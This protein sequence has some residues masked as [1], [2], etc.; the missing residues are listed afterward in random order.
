MIYNH[1]LALAA[2]QAK[3]FNDWKNTLK[4]LVMHER[5]LNVI[6]KKPNDARQLPNGIYITRGEIEDSI[7]DEDNYYTADFINVLLLANQDKSI[8]VHSAI[9]DEGMVECF[10]KIAFQQE[11]YAFV[12]INIAYAGNETN[13]KNHWVALI[14]DRETSL[15][16]YLDPAHKPYTDHLKKFICE[17]IGNISIIINPIDFQISEKEEGFIR[18]CGVYVIEIFNVFSQKASVICDLSTLQVVLS[19]IPCG[20]AQRIRE[21]RLAHIEKACQILE[22]AGELLSSNTDEHVSSEKKGKKNEN[23]ARQDGRHSSIVLQSVL[24]QHTE[25]SKLL[26][27]K[28]GKDDKERPPELVDTNAMHPYQ[29]FIRWLAREDALKKG[30]YLCLSLDPFDHG[31]NPTFSVKVKNYLHF[32]FRTA[33]LPQKDSSTLSRI[34]VSEIFSESVGFWTEKIWPIIFSGLLLHDG[35]TYFSEPLDRYGNTVLGMLVGISPNQLAWG[36]HLGGDRPDDAYFWIPIGLPLLLSS[37]FAIYK[38]IQRLS[39][40]FDSKPS[41][42][43]EDTSINSSSRI[44]TLRFPDGDTSVHLE[45]EEFKLEIDNPGLRPEASLF[46]LLW[47]K[48]LS[49]KSRME[50]LKNIRGIRGG[51]NLFYQMQSLARLVDGFDLK[52][53]KLA[54]VTQQESLTFNEIYKKALDSIQYQVGMKSSTFKLKHSLSRIYCE[55]LLWSLGKSQNSLMHLVFVPLAFFA[56]YAKLR[57]WIF[58]AQKA[59]VFHNYL[60]GLKNCGYQ[61][62]TWLY[63][64]VSGQFECTVCGDNPFVYYSDVFTS[65]G[66]LNGLFSQKRTPEE[67][68]KYLG[69]ILRSP[70]FMWIDLSQQNWL[71]WELQQ[72]SMFLNNISSVTSHLKAFNLSYPTF[73]PIFPNASHLP[74]FKE[75][76]KIVS[77]D[78]LDIHNRGMGDRLLAELM[79]ALQN[80]SLTYLDLSFNQLT[81]NAAIKIGKFIASTQTLKTL[82]IARNPLGDAGIRH[83]V[84]ALTNSS[85]IELDICDTY[86]GAEGTASIATI[87]ESPQNKIKTLD[88]STNDISLADANQLGEAVKKSLSLEELNLSETN[89]DDVQMDNFMSSAVQGKTL[90]SIDVSNNPLTDQ[91]MFLIINHIK[92]AKNSRITAAYFNRNFITDDGMVYIA[93]VLQDTKLEKMSV[94]NAK[95]FTVNGLSKLL[96]NLPHE[97]FYLDI[98]GND[99][100]D[101]LADTFVKIF[102]NG[103]A[104]GLKSIGLGSNRLTDTSGEMLVRLFSVHNVTNLSLDHNQLTDKTVQALAEVF[105]ENHFVSLDLSYNKIANDT[106]L[107]SLA[108]KLPGSKLEKLSLAHNQLTEKSTVAIAENI[109]APPTPHITELGQATISLDE[110]KA[111]RKTKPNTNLTEVD[112]SYNQIHVYGALGL[113]RVWPNT[114]IPIENLRIEG[115]PIDEFDIHACEASS[116]SRLRPFSFFSQRS[117]IFLPEITSS[118]HGLLPENPALPGLPAGRGVPHQ[119]SPTSVYLGVALMP[120]IGTVIISLIALYLIYRA[121]SP[122]MNSLWGNQSCFFRRHV[123]ED[124]ENEERKNSCTQIEL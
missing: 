62:K 89:M 118:A 102:N 23:Q 25:T 112:V 28:N 31:K 108:T 58:L 56:M 77:I 119:N 81:D 51:L 12:P 24:E 86:F 3:V 37:T 47:D 40:N 80:H 39:G 32:L 79:D 61:N 17:Y 98:S 67:I 36:T 124:E 48:K 91:G 20:Q 87:I 69:P 84:T 14:I 10:G 15:C 113:C 76:L 107:V 94:A 35:I 53:L 110:I 74:T 4:E 41:L 1:R 92:N 116:S 104:Y 59:Y 9:T 57:F 11:R 21:M 18:H 93:R 115:N 95:S 52:S 82:K 68:L 2:E 26:P 73:S 7:S 8:R 97:L 101:D 6:G 66:C 30:L 88:L 117:E 42:S 75:F 5:L 46:S 29:S 64:P 109:V 38:C 111:L 90:R 123:K 60:D 19:Q 114:E 78:M 96:A 33:S 13:I 120:G 105:P 103:T 70:D 85:I 44:I 34:A 22:D 100:G 45:N 121:V 63:M 83:M 27:V 43:S 16:F 71:G 106:G 50:K 99:L 72:W 55:Y 54:G 122:T 65:Q 49:N